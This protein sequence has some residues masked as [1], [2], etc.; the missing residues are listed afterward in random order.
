MWWFG[1][2]EKWKCESKVLACAPSNVA[3]DNLLEKLLFHRPSVRAVRLGHPTRMQETIQNRS[4][5][6][7]LQ[8]LFHV[9]ARPFQRPHS[10]VFVGTRLCWCRSGSPLWFATLFW[11]RFYLV[12]EVLQICRLTCRT[13]RRP[14]VLTWLKAWYIVSP[15]R[16]LRDPNWISYYGPGQNV[17]VKCWW[18]LAWPVIDASCTP[19]SLLS[20]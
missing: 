19:K 6:A 13:Y 17:F 9:H 20:L 5:D 10:L 3:V 1:S 7:I 16:V 2:W 4:L 18:K 15:R 12:C 14:L 11:C 8:V